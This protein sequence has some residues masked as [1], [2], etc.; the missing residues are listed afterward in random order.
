MMTEFERDPADWLRRFSPDEWIAAAM[1]ELRRAED[2]YKRS[3]ARAGLAGCKRAAGMALNGALI[4]EPNPAWGRTYVEHVEAL[5]REEKVPEAVR[6][7]CKVVLETRAP[8]HDLLSLRSKGGRALGATVRM[9][10]ERVLEA[11]RDV[12]AHAYAVV[13]RHA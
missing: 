3:D 12:I 9:G 6:A 13:K 4:V 8:S 5:A 11:T 10:D 1:G 2:A 7:A